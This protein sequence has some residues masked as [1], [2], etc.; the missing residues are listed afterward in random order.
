MGAISRHSGLCLVLSFMTDT[1]IKKHRLVVGVTGASGALYA[2]LLFDKLL[3]IHEQIDACGVI[4]SSS[5]TRVWDYELDKAGIPPLPWPVYDPGDYFAPM[6]SGSAAYRTM[7]ICPATMGVTGRI[8][9]G[10]ANDLITRAADVV[11][12][13]R[14]RLVLVVREMPYSLIHL[15]NMQLLT[16]AGAIVCPASPSFYSKPGNIEAL[17]MTVVERALTLAG[18][19][20]KGYRWQE[21]PSPD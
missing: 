8:A 10:L 1:E 6:A 17:A 15:K 18:F 20:I 5:A 16:E 21:P 3:Q 7:I 13:E 2:K 12:K 19:D 9:S 11:L 4:F 14:G